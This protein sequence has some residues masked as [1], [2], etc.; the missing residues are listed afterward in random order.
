LEFIQATGWQLGAGPVPEAARVIGE[1]SFPVQVRL[2][3][4]RVLREVGRGSMGVVYEAEQISLGRRVALKILPFASA[5]DPRQRQRFLIE[6]QAAA[7]LHHP[8]IVPIFGAG[9]DQGIHFYAMQYV[10]GRTLGELLSEFCKEDADTGKDQPGL[11]FNDKEPSA[12]TR[13]ESVTALL[14][15]VSFT[16]RL[17]ETPRG[18]PSRLDPAHSAL[19]TGSDATVSSLRTRSRAREIARLGRQAAEALEHA[20]GLGVVYRDIKPA[21]LMVDSGG[22]LW[23]TDFSLARFRG[24]L[25][26]TRSGDLVGMLRYMSPEQALARRGVVDQRTDIYAL[27]LT[28]YELLTLRPAFDGKITTSCS[29]RLRWMSQFLRAGS[30]RR[31]RATWKRSS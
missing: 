24:D 28:L 8:H 10:D 3:D 30:I 12:V 11:P 21:N 6:A 9:C 15:T 22:E 19:V 26:L 20:H 27:G 16:P 13:S 23:I 17:A 5:I 18:D 14:Q 4:Y 31:F 2:G 29:D 1:Q 7:Q 25:S